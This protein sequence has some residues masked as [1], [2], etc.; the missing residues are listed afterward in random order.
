M[1]ETS[2]LPIAPTT[3]AHPDCAT[4]VRDETG[5]NVT[6]PLPNGKTHQ[7]GACPEHREWFAY[8][9]ASCDAGDPGIIEAGVRLDP[10]GRHPERVIA[11]FETDPPVQGE[12]AL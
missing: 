8:A 2:S 1:N 4:I 7:G 6:F 10:D 9:V 5:T 3:C 12:L 11:A